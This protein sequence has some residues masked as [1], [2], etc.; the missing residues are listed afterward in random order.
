MPHVLNTAIRAAI[1]LGGVAVVVIPGDVATRDAPSR[2]VEPAAGL[3]PERPTVRPRDREL[4][5]LAGLL[6]EGKRVTLLCGRGCAEAR[7]EL[8]ELA[9]T[10]QAPIVHALGGKE[11]VEWDNP[12]DV[13]MTGLLGVTS[14]Y[15]AMME[16]DVLLMLGTDF[17]YRQFFPEDAKIAQVDIRPD[18][19][20]RRCSLHLGVVGDVAATI[21]ALIPRL[22]P[23]T[24]RKHLDKSLAHYAK[25]REGLDELAVLERDDKELHPQQVA[26]MVSELAAADAIFTANVGTPTIWVARYLRMNGRRR[27]VGSWVHGSMAG[28]LPQ[29]IG[30]QCAFPGRQVISLS[31]DGGFTMMMGDFLTLTQEKLPVKV[32][33]FNNGSLG[34]VEL[35]MKAAGLLPTGV[36]LVNP[37]FAAMARAIG[38]HAVRVDDPAKLEEAVAEV[39]AHEGPA[40]LDAVVSRRE[41]S[42]PPK[43]TLEQVKGF[44]LYLLK[45]VM[46]GQGNEL[47]ELARTNLA[48]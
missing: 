22:E 20:G 27:L 31:G 28:A 36:S 21:E 17:P 47:I 42:M 11:Y 40:L 19:L 13:G 24:D 34:F 16:C 5:S 39:L 8:L 4:D 45:A 29:A 38:V 46:N 41:L 3:I 32:V 26:R 9:G 43:V 15:Y 30:G 18:Q 2:S 12:Y 6:N 37:D 7:S 48:K 44:S 25:T 10:L 33:V 14:G 1:G 35:E 23:R